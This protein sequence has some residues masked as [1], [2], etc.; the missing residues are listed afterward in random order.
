[1]LPCT[2]KGLIRVLRMVRQA[3]EY[4]CQQNFQLNFKQ[5]NDRRNVVPCSMLFQVA[6]GDVCLVGDT[7][8]GGLDPSDPKAKHSVR[9]MKQATANLIDC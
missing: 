1:M 7:L 8:L 6:R 5:M 2:R 9:N 3:V 4:L